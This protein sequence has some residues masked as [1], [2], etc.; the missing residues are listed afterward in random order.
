MSD[1]EPPLTP[2]E[3]L[4]HD[5]ATPATIISLN[6]NLLKSAITHHNDAK[7]AVYLKR[8]EIGSEQLNS[9]LKK[10]RRGWEGGEFITEIEK[11]LTFL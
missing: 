1:D 10:I 8:L 3:K 4:A 9:I 5:L 6:L 7:L 2:Q 11:C